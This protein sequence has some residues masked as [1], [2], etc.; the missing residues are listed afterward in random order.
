MSHYALYL[1]ISRSDQFADK[2]KRTVA[3]RFLQGIKIC[4]NSYKVMTI[5]KRD[6]IFIL[7]NLHKYVLDKH[8][9]V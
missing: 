9:L 2:S 6:G 7:V 4:I 5:L 1:V 3:A 8:I